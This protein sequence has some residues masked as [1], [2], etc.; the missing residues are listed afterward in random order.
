MV[1]ASSKLSFKNRI[2]QR[3]AECKPV[4]DVDEG[5]YISARVFLFIGCFNF[6]LRCGAC[7]AVVE[8]G[9][10]SGNPSIEN[11]IPNSQHYAMIL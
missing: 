9:C 5:Q 3:P 10:I 6:A 4:L 8:L 7:G 2:M 11:R 1:H